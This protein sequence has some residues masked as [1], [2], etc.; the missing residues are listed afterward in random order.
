MEITED[1]RTERGWKCLRL[2]AFF[3]CFRLFVFIHISL[4][5][6]FC[7]PL[8]LGWQYHE[9]DSVLL[10]ILNIKYFQQVKDFK[11]F[12]G[13]PTKIISSVLLYHQWFP[14]DHLLAEWNRGWWQKILLLVTCWDQRTVLNTKCVSTD[15][16]PNIWPWYGWHLVL[17]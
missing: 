12:L 9:P 11:K 1:L 15:K 14:L 4:Q 3:L 7:N 2:A 10:I 13:R 5:C 17:F 6:Q 8:V 16:N